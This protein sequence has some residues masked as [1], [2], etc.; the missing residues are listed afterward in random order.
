MSY[1]KSMFHRIA[2]EAHRI[3]EGGNDDDVTTEDLARMADAI[4][5]ILANRDYMSAES[6]AASYVACALSGMYE[7]CCELPD[8]RRELI[9]QLMR[10]EGF[11]KLENMTMTIWAKKED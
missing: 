5:L 1:D 8:V 10:D 6:D 9:D 2:E 11:D 3:A 7:V 4:A